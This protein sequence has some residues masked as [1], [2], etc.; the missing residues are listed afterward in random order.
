MFWMCFKIQ[1]LPLFKWPFLA[2]DLLHWLRIPSHIIPGWIV[3]GPTGAGHPTCQPIKA[4]SA[5]PHAGQ[6]AA[7]APHRV[8]ART[9]G[10]IL[11][12]TR[13]AAP[14]EALGFVAARRWLARAHCACRFFNLARRARRNI[15]K[16]TRCMVAQRITLIM[17]VL[18]RGLVKRGCGKTT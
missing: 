3:S 17:R 7:P 5:Q 14:N 13:P 18:R 6:P 1:K 11:A 16:F 8:V 2:S 4:G 15:F 12:A 9:G 10:M